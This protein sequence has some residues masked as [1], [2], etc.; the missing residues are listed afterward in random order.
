[1]STAGE[2]PTLTG[3][4][5]C[6]KLKICQASVPDLHLKGTTDIASCAETEQVSLHW[7]GYFNEIQLS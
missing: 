3:F 6:I 2:R 7:C 1:L 4:A 5:V